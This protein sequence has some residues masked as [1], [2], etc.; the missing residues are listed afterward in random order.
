MSPGPTKPKDLDS[1]LHPLVEEF[2]LLEKGVSNVL[3]ASNG[4]TFTLRAYI[5]MATG[6]MPARDDLMGLMGHNSTHG[7]NYCEIKGYVGRY[8]VLS[9]PRDSRAG[10]SD[11]ITEAL[12][13]YYV[14][15]LLGISQRP[16]NSIPLR[17]RTHEEMKA[18]AEYVS[19]SNDEKHSEKGVKR[20]SIFFGLRSIL[21]PWY[22]FLIHFSLLKA[23]NN[24][25]LFL[26]I[27][28]TYST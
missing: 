21:F 8:P 9:P 19:L 23:Y 4:A 24:L 3:D 7:C 5:I 27:L 15:P 13:N 6:D 10:Q 16:T 11:D 28:C 20:R 2:K 17:I 12:P 25:G 22:E 1:F 18:Q 26:W 14:K